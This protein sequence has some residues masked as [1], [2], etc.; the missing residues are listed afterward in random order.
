MLKGG[1]QPI[2]IDNGTGVIKAGFAGSDKPRVVF[3]N[4]LG[5]TKHLRVM[6]GGCLE[7]FDY[8]VGSKAEE[9]RGAFFFDVSNR[10]RNNKKLE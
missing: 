1:N 6:P 5:R 9:Q 2:V 7:G 10:K 3:R 8:F 4:C